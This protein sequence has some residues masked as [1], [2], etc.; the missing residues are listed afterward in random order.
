M[1]RIALTAL[2]LIGLALPALAQITVSSP[3]ATPVTVT[4]SEYYQVAPGIVDGLVAQKVPNDDISVA[5]FLANLAKVTPEA[6]IGYRAKGLS[7]ADI[8]G[9]LGV[10]PDVYFAGLPANPGPPYGK[11]WGYWKK[12][13]AQPTT[14]FNLGDDDLRNLVQLRLVS[15]YYKVKPRT[16]VH[17]RGSG[18]DFSAIIA[19]QHGKKMGQGK[20]KSEDK[21]PPGKAKKE[22]NASTG[23][24]GK[25][26]GQGHGQGNDK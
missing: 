20:P 23:N 6:V 3:G 18:K 14:A 25:G 24:P 13:Q 19:D 21:T 2:I 15:Q 4:Y 8:T 17:W 1:K 12:R 22:S 5:L 26:H 10:K 11:A 16:V 9:Q 7:W